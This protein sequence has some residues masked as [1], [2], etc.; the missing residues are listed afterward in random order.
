MDSINRNQ[1]ELNRRDLNGADAVECLKD[2]VDDAK[3]CFF[4]TQGGIGPSRGMRPMSVREID[5]AG[6]LW[7][8]SASDSH[9]NA[10][11]AANP[12]VKLYFQKCSHSGFVEVDGYAEVLTDRARIK[13]LWNFMLKTWFTEGED[14]PRITAIRVIP[15]QGYY[16]DNKH[17]DTVAGAKIVV[18][19]VLG[20]TLDDSIE[21]TL[22]F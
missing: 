22:S 3:S 11:I 19:A 14:D 13:Q 1:P 15:R 21:G 8:L 6:Q 5:D 20:K 10:E 12:A 4:T 2:I 9:K 17:G 16:W 18:G 7:F